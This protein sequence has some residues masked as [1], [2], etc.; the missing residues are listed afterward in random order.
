MKC[1]TE[2]KINGIRSPQNIRIQIPELNINYSTRSGDDGWAAVHFKAGFK[3]WSPQTPRLY[4]VIIQSETDTV[5]DEIGFRNIEVSGT[6][7]LLNGKPIF[8]KGVNIHEESP[9]K[10]ARAWSA[11]DADTLLHWAKELGC[12]LVRLA[13]YPHNEN[14]V[15][16]AE[17]M[18]LMVW[19][20]IPV[21]QN[22]EFAEAAVREKM[23]LMMRE[24][25]RRDKMVRRHHLE[26][27]Q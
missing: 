3:L 16:M 19:D 26:F 9:F 11:K 18:G 14:M 20:E 25:I 15:R 2:V 21:Y 23:D 5:T 13:H 22:I 8:L 4:K 24:M 6:R 1:F 17:K 27:V 10:A 12:N 7:I